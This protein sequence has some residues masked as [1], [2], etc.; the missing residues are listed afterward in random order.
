[1]NLNFG[2]STM[3]YYH[4]HIEKILPY[5]ADWQIKNIEIRP[6]IGH[7]EFQDSNSIDHIKKKIDHSGILV[8]AIHMPMNGVDISHPE[9]YD[10]V[11]S[12]R[13]VEKAVLVAHRLGAGLV[14]VHPGGMCNNFSDRGKRLSHSI[15][16]LREIVEFSQQWN[17]KLAIENTPPG[18][19]GD[20][21]EEIHKIITEIISEYIGICFD[22]GHYILNKKN[23]GKVKLNLEKEPINWQKNLFH[24]HIHD[25]DRKQDLH[26]LPGEGRFLWSSLISFLQEIKYNGYLILEPKDQIDI[27]SY[28]NK[29]NKVFDSLRC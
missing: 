4:E 8:K 11:K 12:I 20:Q 13:E 10:R 19:L 1:M 23:I 3:V 29:I 15:N 22:T 21:W 7:F 16:S 2:I 5:L 27:T 14:V 6:H 24:I 26:L 28:L 17:V 25:N 18:R 9:E